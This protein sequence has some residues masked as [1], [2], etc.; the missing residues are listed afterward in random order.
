MN[1]QQLFKLVESDLQ[2]DCHGD[3]LSVSRSVNAQRVIE[4][5]ASDRQATLRALE[6]YFEGCRPIEQDLL[7]VMVCTRWGH[8]CQD[9]HLRLPETTTPTPE[10]LTRATLQQWAADNVYSTAR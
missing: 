1:H 7:E 6:L 2:F 8:V 10:T 4:L 3:V 5:A 9:I